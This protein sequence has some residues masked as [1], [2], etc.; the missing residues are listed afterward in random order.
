MPTTDSARVCELL[1]RS[2]YRVEAAPTPRQ[3]SLVLKVKVLVT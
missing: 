2:R 3:G 1:A